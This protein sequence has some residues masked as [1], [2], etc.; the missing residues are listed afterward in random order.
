MKVLYFHQHFT[1]PE[2]SGGTRSYEFAKNLVANGHQVTLVCGSYEGGHTGLEGLFKDNIREGE[3]EGIRVIELNI[4]YSNKDSL[5][6]RS[7]KFINY[8]LRSLSIVL[9]TDFDLLFST[10]T[11]LTAAIPGIFSKIIFKGKFI[12]EVRDLWP[13]LPKAMGVIENPVLIFLLNSLE[14]IAYKSAD[15]L[16]GLSPGIVEGIKSKSDR[17]KKVVMIPNGSDLNLFNSFQTSDY[18]KALNEIEESDF[19][20]IY[21]GTHGKANGLHVLAEAARELKERNNHKIKIVLI[22]D[23][24]EKITL[25]DYKDQNQ[26]DNLIF[27]PPLPK[28]KLGSWMTRANIGLQILSNIP[29]FYY[30]TSPNKFFDYLSS[31]L[32]VLVNYPG[33][34]AD[35]I[36]KEKIGYYADPEDSF[37]IVDRLEEAYECRNNPKFSLSS[38]EVAR[39][40]FDRK[41]L[42]LHF[43]DFLEEIYNA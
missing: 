3:I 20:A 27:I 37:S 22:G 11:P 31:D 13:E 2:G 19:I 18:V 23:G 17:S 15:G 16:I 21:T 38:L 7:R 9:K 42:F 26:L 6:R 25:L 36:E 40:N 5:L 34:V 10:S 32:P 28:N 29:E 8:S 14:K 35:I 12:F 24:S 43:Q 4:P 39:N 30:G 41:K 33:W 1:T